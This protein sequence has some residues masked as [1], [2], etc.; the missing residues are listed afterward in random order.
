M[1]MKSDYLKLKEHLDE[2]LWEFE[3]ILEEKGINGIEVVL[4]EANFV[5]RSRKSKTAFSLRKILEECFPLGAKNIEE[6]HI[7]ATQSL[8]N[9][10]KY[11]ET[12]IKV[13]LEVVNSPNNY[14]SSLQG[15]A[16][17]ILE[18][19]PDLHKKTLQKT[20]SKQSD[21]PIPLE[22]TSVQ[23]L[24]DSVSLDSVF[25]SKDAPV[26]TPKNCTNL[27][28]K[29]YTKDTCCTSSS[30]KEKAE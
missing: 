13:L 28:D 15:L 26:A 6:K 1:T 2:I 12:A 14:S 21:N 19:L 11:S 30:S 18:E 27:N 9:L 23:V 20:G 24:E 25:F 3:K 22:E 17:K 5:S 8:L 16:V 4:T 29:N 7:L 10:N